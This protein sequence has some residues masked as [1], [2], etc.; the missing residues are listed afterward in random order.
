MCVGCHTGEAEYPFIRLTSLQ[1]RSCVPQTDA[2]PGAALPVPAVWQQP[3]LTW[4]PPPSLHFPEILKAIK[5][6]E[7]E[8][9]QSNLG[10]V[11]RR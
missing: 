2:P 9:L 10:K 11:W 7:I 1:Q 3:R 5:P 4:R 6:D 8:R